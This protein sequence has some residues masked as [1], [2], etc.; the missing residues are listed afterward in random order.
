MLV[1]SKTQ[2]RTTLT[3]ASKGSTRASAI[4]TRDHARRRSRARREN[5][6][7]AKHCDAGAVLGSTKG[8]HVLANVAANEL[9]EVGAAVGQDILDEIVSELIASN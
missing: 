6:I 2:S 5:G 9:A 8:H 7:A 4:V 3:E 1:I